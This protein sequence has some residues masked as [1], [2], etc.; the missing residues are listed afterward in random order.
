MT[1]TQPTDKARLPFVFDDGGRAASGF[2][3]QADDCVV[4]AVA[5]ASGLPYTDVYQV[6]A[7]GVGSERGSKGATAR[8]GVHTD[9]KWFREY[10]Q[11]LGFVWVPTMR[12][13][14]G[15]TTHLVRGE[16]PEG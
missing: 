16:L 15:C 4:R 13:G 7:K 3:G 12:V 14:Q 5:I 9:R 10:M 6:I 8:R 2:R 11:S 1:T